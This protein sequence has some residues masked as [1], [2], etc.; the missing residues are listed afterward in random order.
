MSANREI[1]NLIE[2]ELKS[3]M[4]SLKDKDILVKSKNRE[5]AKIKLEKFL[6]NKKIAF[7]SVFKKSKSGSLDVLTITNFGTD[8]I[9]KPIIQKGA[10]GI[11]F[12]KEL[13]VDLKNY[14]NGSELNEL[15]HQDVVVALAKTLKLQQTNNL[16]VVGEGSKNQRRSLQFNG[17]KLTIDNSTGKTLTDI[18]IVNKKNN[19]LKYLSLKM[20][21]SYYTLSASIG[22]YFADKKTKVAINTFFGFSGAWMSG[23]GEEY[24]CR[25]PAANYSIVSNNL[26]NVLSQAV[27]TNVVLVH[28]RGP[29]DVL[30]KV[31]G[32]NNAVTI[33]GLN[34]QSYSYPIFGVRKY[35]NI[36]FNASINGASYIVN[37]QF[38]GTTAADV[39]PKYLRILLERI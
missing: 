7:Q 5:E 17:S 26:A 2:R 9:F 14:F 33:S 18:T 27:G 13:E 34:Q 28:K 39:G 20:S 6:K 8:V 32:D 21:R 30:V 1:I 4:V 37:F 10:G 38:R 19:S 36:K 25:T 12:E 3:D 29:G 15:K 22:S 11:L 31:I 16:D 35:A 23:F 24:G